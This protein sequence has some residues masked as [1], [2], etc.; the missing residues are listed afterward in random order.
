GKGISP[1]ANASPGSLCADWPSAAYGKPSTDHR[2]EECLPASAGR[3]RVVLALRLLKGIVN[4]DRKGWMRLFGAAVHR[5]R[6]AVKEKFFCRLLAAMPV[7]R[8]N[9]FFCLRHGKR[10]KEIRKD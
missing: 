3:A 1:N 8:G 4:C 7:G 6:H 9:Q 10:G 5:L 2:I